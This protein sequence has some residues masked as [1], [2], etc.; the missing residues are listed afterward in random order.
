[1]IGN[2]S[3]NNK[4]KEKRN[5]RQKFGLTLKKQE[6]VV[7]SPRKGYFSVL[8]RLLNIETRPNKRKSIEKSILSK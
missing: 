2:G 4:I 6:C 1:M 7:F 3:R 8:I 5:K